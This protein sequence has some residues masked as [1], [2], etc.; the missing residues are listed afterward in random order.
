MG[1]RHKRLEFTFV[2]KIVAETC[3]FA[4]HSLHSGAESRS[5]S[6][7]VPIFYESPPLARAARAFF[8][9]EPSDGL[10]RSIGVGRNSSSRNANAN[11]QRT[12]IRRKAFNIFPNP[13]QT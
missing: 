13:T 5:R 7:R 9:A 10:L 4:M 12:K 8:S 3:A 6:E 11:T 1:H 2:S